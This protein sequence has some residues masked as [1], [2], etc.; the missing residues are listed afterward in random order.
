MRSSPSKADSSSK[1]LLMLAKMGLNQQRVETII[2]GFTAA[3][4]SYNGSGNQ[5]VKAKTKNPGFIVTKMA[6]GLTNQ[7]F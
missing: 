7:T 4:T 2:A 1:T 6:L 5:Q 3:L